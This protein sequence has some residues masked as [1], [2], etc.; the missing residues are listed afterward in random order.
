MATAILEFY[1]IEKMARISLH[2]FNNENEIDRLIT[3]LQEI[4]KEYKK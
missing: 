4:I 1:H 3:A 2:Y